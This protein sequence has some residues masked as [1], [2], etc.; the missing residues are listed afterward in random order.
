[1]TLPIVV[2][3]EI[4]AALENTANLACVPQAQSPLIA[5]AYH[6]THPMIPII[7]VSAET[8]V[9]WVKYVLAVSARLE[10]EQ[11]IVTAYPETHPMIPIIAVSAETRVPLV[12]PVKMEYVRIQQFLTSFHL[13][14]IFN[15]II[16]LRNPFNGAFSK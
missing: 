15:Q 6:E 11:P 13:G 12:K 9:A 14:I 2:Y 7:A 1:M 10:Q 8:S 16:Q 5:M 3:V 4:N